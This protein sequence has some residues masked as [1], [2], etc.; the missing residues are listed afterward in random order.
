MQTKATEV[1]HQ[2][3]SG[4]IRLA[5]KAF[6]LSMA[7]K[8]TGG[9]VQIEIKLKAAGDLDPETVTPII[10]AGRSRITYRLFDEPRQSSIELDGSLNSTKPNDPETLWLK[11]A[12]PEYITLTITHATADLP[13]LLPLLQKLNYT[14]MLLWV[15]F[16]PYQLKLL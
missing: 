9:F 1:A 11:M 5:I 4:T 13:T 3:L 15:T 12:D 6:Y 2:I 8:K 14:E 10:T 7:H 16:T